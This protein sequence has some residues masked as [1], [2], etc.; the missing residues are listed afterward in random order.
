MS[1]SSTPGGTELH[2]TGTAT[3]D[4]APVHVNGSPEADTAAMK[5]PQ[6]NVLVV[7]LGRGGVPAS[8]RI[9]AAAR[10]GETM[11]ET[12]VYFGHDGVPVMRTNYFRRVR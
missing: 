3:L 2:S 8:T 11:V 9:Y 10:G 6:R 5:Q 4:G 7:A 1:T 12:A